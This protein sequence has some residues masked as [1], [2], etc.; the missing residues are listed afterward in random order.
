MR[1]EVNWRLVK[2]ILRRDL[3][4]YFSAPTGY[5]FITLFIF[6]SAVAAFWQERFFANNLANL[7]QLNDLFP[8]LLLFF[9]PALTMNIWSE[10][11][12]R[13]TD[14]LL[15]TLPATDLEIVLGKYL[16]CLGIYT[17]SLLLSCSHV[18]V[19]FWLGSPDLGLTFA[20]FI[21]YW[22]LGGALVSIGML[23]SLLTSNLT[24]GFV[25]GALF[26]AVPI[27]ADS[28]TLVPIDLLHRLISPLGVDVPFRAF[29]RGI[30]SLSALLYF[31]SIGALFLWLNVIL[32]GRRHWPPKADGYPMAG[33]QTVRA[34]AL[35]AALIGFNVLLARIDLRIDVTAERLH[36]LSDQTKQSIAALPSDSPVLIQ[37]YL[38]KDVPRNYVEVRSTLV[39]T[40]QEI[41]ARGGS[42]VQVLINDTEPFSDQAREAR[43]K[44]GIAPREVMS[45]E[46]ARTSSREIFMGVAFTSGPREQ[47]IPFFD[48]GLPVEYE[49]V[50]TI[51]VVANAQRKR[52]GVVETQAKL[53]G[54][55]DYTTMNNQPPWSVV[56]E[57]RK[58]YEVVQIAADDSITEQVDALLAVLPSSL[59]QTQMDNL[60]SYIKSGVP[61]LLIDDPLPLVDVNLSPV[62]PS[63]AQTNPF[64]QRN[65]T[66]PPPKGN[67]IEFMGKLGLTWSHNTIAWDAFNPHPGLQT[68]PPEIVF[69][70][71]GNDPSVEAFNSASPITSGL[72]EVVLLYPGHVFKAVDNNYTFTPLLRSGRISGVHR[73]EQLIQRSFFGISMNRNI[74]RVQ[75]P[76]SYIL[77]GQISSPPSPMDST[78]GK[79]D[80]VFIADVDFISEQFFQLRQQGDDDLKFDNVTLFL[81]CIDALA[82]DS[83]FVD[84][85]KK[86]VTYRTLETVEQQTRQFIEARMA[87]EKTAEA[88]A[89]QAL[90]EARDRLNQKVAELQAR[91][92]IDVQTRAI[93]VQNVQEVEN[94]RFEATQARIEADKQA[95]IRQGKETMESQV[96]AIQSRIKTLAV[97]LPPVPVFVMGVL[98]FVRRRR[99]E[100]EGELA[101]R[102]LRS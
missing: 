88:A 71:Q 77:A 78:V 91:E 50:R 57:L 86:R 83:S 42:K 84:L 41:A 17:A 60:V 49:V 25:L 64:S 76:D 13:G 11:R 102:R 4:A 52:I 75:T 100:R 66:P 63:G 3:R 90:T 23:A 29:A 2:T 92:D 1:F 94:R 99:R 38:S 89:Q 51:R 24:V 31:L 69:V 53:F 32:L 8:L 30:L 93:M 101:S 37:A 43:E 73:W 72:Q 48:R 67:I 79:L 46:S 34:V 19:L 5:V 26:C 81:N 44:F 12:R 10:E 58:Q 18:F 27:Y 39:N 56:N 15:L 55:F 74:R 22:L 54:G 80:V 14:E 6:L 98:I 9:I 70:A 20:N 95:T 36:S 68:V 16:A 61:T 7:D 59:S 45:I 62:L 82:G 28:S 65:Q 47:V 35:A 87:N 85:R 96:R 21:G 40:L 33:H 97:A